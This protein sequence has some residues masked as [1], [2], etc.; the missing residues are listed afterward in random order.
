MW[1]RVTHIVF[2]FRLLFILLIAAITAYMGYRAQEVEWSF[3][4]A[5]AVPAH[6]PDMIYF[7][8]FKKQFG[9][10]GNIMVIG[11]QDSSVFEIE[12]F[13]KFDYLTQDISGMKGV[14][15]VLAIPTIQR[16]VKDTEAKKFV[17]EPVIQE[18]PEDQESLDIILEKVI[19][20]RFYSGQIIN[21]ENGATLMLISIEKEILDSKNRDVLVN[22][23]LR[24]GGLFEENTGIKLHYSGLPFVRSAVTTK[25]GGELQMFL[26]LSVLITGLIMFLFFRSGKAVIFPMII[27]GVIVIWVMG[28]LAILGYKIT[29]L[30]GLLPP[31][32]VVIGIPNSV[33]LLNKYH[34]EYE[35]HGNKTLALSRV[36]RK[37]GLVTLITNVTTA[38]GFGVLIFI[39]IPILK[40]FGT[41]ASINIMATFVVSII[42]IPAVF[43]YLPP[44]NTRQLKH[45]KFRPTDK[46]LTTF[47]LLVHRH[48]Y[49]IFAVFAVIVSISAI[50]LTRLYSV[51]FLVDDI[52]EETSIM[53]DLRFFERNFSGVMP[54]E[55]VVDTGKRK[56]AMQLKNLQKVEELEIFLEQ[57]EDISRPISL[58]SF[59]KAARQ[60]FYNENPARYGLPNKQDKNFIFRYINQNQES[61]EGE[62][63]NAFVD[64]TSQMLRVSLKVAD[65]GSIQMD[66]LVS[67]V[68][69]PEIERIFAGTDIDVTLTGTTLLFIQ[70]NRFL[71]ENLR[72]SFLLAFF[73][74]AIIMAILFGN[75]KMIIM[76]LIPNVIPLLMTAG[77]MGFF[78]IPIK[79]STA[80][81]FSIVFGISVDYSIHFLAKYRMELYSNNFFVPVA[82]S[83][84]IR[85][86]GSSMVYTS[87]IL[88]AGFIIFSFSE[89]GGTIALGILTSCTLFIA[90]FTNLILLPAMLLTFDSGK[91]KKGA[92]PFIEQYDEFYHESDDEEIDLGKLQTGKN[93]LGVD[94]ILEKKD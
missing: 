78:D 80:L 46:L 47:D 30:T 75:F 10:D 12:N 43:S 82:V 83:K 60:A 58:A 7:E 13:R 69:E 45:L 18:F 73:L 63:I 94:E 19:D 76:S 81:I 91:R 33:Y 50:G 23:I 17:L 39:D 93:G 32:I 53:K 27:I 28:T 3:D 49:R 86:M 71:I 38:I 72:N 66:S 24:S 92:H 77:I 67:K 5:K 74:I 16:L 57:Q 79:P 9:Q 84:S 64:S 62:L 21:Q 25:V 29:L 8:G 54:L 55:I 90:M 56:G 42:L 1:T 89:F 61:E 40:E 31:I 36:V 15:T 20:L 4:F 85:E 88:F 11:L 68:I 48:R 87:I 51:S 22:D 6:H 26:I 52:P 44:P 34:Q 41:V 59:V 2:K 35:R 37:I 14:Q 70:G 65:I